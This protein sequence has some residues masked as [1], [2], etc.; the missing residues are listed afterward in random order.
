MVKN[1]IKEKKRNNVDKAVES[2]VKGLPIDISSLSLDFRE[3]EM[4]VARVFSSVGY[5]VYTNFILKKP[6][7]EID[8]LAVIEDFAV[9]IDCKHWLRSKSGLTKV[10]RLQKERA[11]Q[12]ITTNEIPTVRK[13]VPA[14][15][16]QQDYQLGVCY[17]VPIVPISKIF[18]FAF[19]VRGH[20]ELY[21]T[22]QRQVRN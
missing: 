10:A 20:S 4:F 12:L 19:Q 1:N 14:V 18:N 16:T 15:V 5:D 6:R 9:A 17:G 8:L 13:A 7:R 2:V 22:A 3:F 21:I 11:I